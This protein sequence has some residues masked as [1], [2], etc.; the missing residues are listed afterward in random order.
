MRDE[1]EICE[2]RAN[3]SKIDSDNY[4]G[5]DTLALDITLSK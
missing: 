1:Y 3:H 4:G 2:N 5:S